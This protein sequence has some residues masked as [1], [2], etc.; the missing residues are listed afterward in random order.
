MPFFPPNLCRRSLA[1][2][3]ITLTA[4]EIDRLEISGDESGVH[5]LR[6]WETEM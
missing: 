1:S 2:A 6:E 3:R 4:D 5:T